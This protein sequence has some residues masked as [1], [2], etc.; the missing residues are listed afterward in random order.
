MA[1][2]PRCGCQFRTLGD[3]PCPWCGLSP[4]DVILH[5][6]DDEDDEDDMEG[7]DNAN[8]A[9]NSADCD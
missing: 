4:W 3:H 9:S 6:R 5:G 2:C 8:R 7:S 1:L